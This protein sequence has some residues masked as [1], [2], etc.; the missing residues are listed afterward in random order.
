MTYD[1]IDTN[2]TAGIETIDDQGSIDLVTQ[3]SARELTSDGSN[4]F[5][6]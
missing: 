6:I 5:I 2:K 4:Y 3:F 1:A